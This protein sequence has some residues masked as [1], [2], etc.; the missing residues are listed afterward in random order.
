VALALDNLKGSIMFRRSVGVLSGS[1]FRG[2]ESLEA[3]TFAAGSVVREISK[4][5]FDGSGLKH[6][7]SSIGWGDR[8]RGVLGANRL[9]GRHSNPDRCCRS[10]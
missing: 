7:S 6:G 4:F 5:A 9:L 8:Q 2:C 10:C 3:I 1:C